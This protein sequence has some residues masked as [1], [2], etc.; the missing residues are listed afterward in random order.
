MD[1]KHIKVDK[2]KKKI[3]NKKLIKIKKKWSDM[4]P[5]WG[6]YMFLTM[7][8]C[9]IPPCFAVPPRHS[10]YFLNWLQFTRAVC[11]YII[12]IVTPAIGPNK[13]KKLTWLYLWSCVCVC[14]VFH[15]NF[16]AYIVCW[17]YKRMSF[18]DLF[19]LI[20]RGN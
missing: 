5:I 16:A 6:F 11:G 14:V 18:F 9:L 15:S 12:G 10:S 7:T 3:K 2:N 17:C 19:G 8:L 20:C 4:T 13:S 1:N